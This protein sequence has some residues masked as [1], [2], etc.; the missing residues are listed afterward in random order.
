MELS[1]DNAMIV[2]IAISSDIL[3]TTPFLITML[4]LVKRWQM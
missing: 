3:E 1:G 2:G 4:K